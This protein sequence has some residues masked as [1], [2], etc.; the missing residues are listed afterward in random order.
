MPDIP[1]ALYV[2]ARIGANPSCSILPTHTLRVALP[3]NSSLALTP[4]FQPPKAVLN[5]EAVELQYPHTYVFASGVPFYLGLYTGN[6]SNAPSNGIYSDPLFGW[7]ELVNRQGVIQLLDSALV[8]KAGGIYA[9]TEI[10][11]D[12]PEPSVRSLLCLGCLLLAAVRRNA[13]YSL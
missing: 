8:Y 10:F 3:N 11:W 5:A 9:G 2:T 6:V 1:T 13:A 7:A 4:P 12:V